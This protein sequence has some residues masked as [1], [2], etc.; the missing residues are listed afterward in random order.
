MDNNNQSED[1][2][3]NSEFQ[4]LEVWI[5]TMKTS[6]D[7]IHHRIDSIERLLE[8][9]TFNFSKLILK[10]KTEKVTDFLLQIGINHSITLEEFLKALN[11]WLINSDLVDLNDLQIIVTP[12]I[13]ATFEK[14]KGL[15]KVPYPFL[16]A[17]LPQLFII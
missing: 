14:T 4:S 11:R 3:T 17:S 7:L 12:Q 13:E 1:S 2:E 6:G 8:Q 10:A 5:Q 16:L 9:E 15:Q